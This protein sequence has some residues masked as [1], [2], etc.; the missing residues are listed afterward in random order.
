MQYRVLCFLWGVGSGVVLGCPHLMVGTRV[1]LLSRFFFI[2]D[3]ASKVFNGILV[4]VFHEG[5]GVSFRDVKIGQLFDIVFVYSSSYFSGNGN[6]GVGSPSIVLQCGDYWIIF[7]VFV[8]V[9]LF[10]EFIMT[11]CELGE[12]Y[13]VVWG[14]QYWCLCLIEGSNDA[15]HVR[16]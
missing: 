6:E 9:T 11:L 7:G 14:G 2:Q 12:L 4:C 1:C 13:V 3:H 8:C 10:G 16:S 5:F 15:H